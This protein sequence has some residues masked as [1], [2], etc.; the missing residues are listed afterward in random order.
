M[1]PANVF[2]WLKRKAETAD[3]RIAAVLYE[4]VERALGRRD[5]EL[6]RIVASM[7]GLLTC[8]AYADMDFDEREVG[9]IRALLGGV[10]GLSPAAVEA[11]VAVLRTDAVRISGA[12][13]TV[14]ARELLELTAEDTRVELLDALVDVAAAD[15]TISLAETNVLR[16]V[17]HALGLSQAEY[18]RAQARHRDKLAVLQKR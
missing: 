12:E 15:G 2:A 10:R 11:I 13:A 17:A 1:L 3:R 4:T 9:R 5:P 7:A 8:V 16:P 18:N 6:V 14:Y